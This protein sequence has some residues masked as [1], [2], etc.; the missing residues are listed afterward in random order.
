M[1]PF[2]VAAAESAV[3]LADPR[4]LLLLFE[5][6]LDVADATEE[7]VVVGDTS[8]FASP[9]RSDKPSNVTSAFSDTQD[10]L[11][12]LKRARMTVSRS[13]I[14]KFVCASAINRGMASPNVT[15]E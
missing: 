6:E 8:S 13:G 1:I 4:L 3:V 11:A 15:F 14:E 2:A 9:T 5:L 12:E 7:E 10:K